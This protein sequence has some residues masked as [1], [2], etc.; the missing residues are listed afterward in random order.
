M[1]TAARALNRAKA[2]TPLP[3]VAELLPLHE[4][5]VLPRLGQ[6]MMI[7]GQPGAGKSTFVLWYAFKLGLDCLYFS[8]DMAAHTATTR[9]GALALDRTV[10]FVSDAVENGGTEFVQEALAES[11]IQW[12]F[13]SSPSL[14]DIADELA[15]YVEIW[16]KYPELII[17]DN[18][19]NVDGVG[20]DDVGG[21]RFVLSEL[22]R[23]CRETGS[24]VIALHHAREEGDPLRPS[25]RDKIQGKVSQLP[26]LIITVA[27]DGPEFLMAPVKNRNGFQDPTGNTYRRLTAHPE[28]ASFTTFVPKVYGY[29]YQ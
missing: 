20:G 15:A 3:I 22:H 24:A 19:L 1:L 25:P 4:L 8:A 14:D 10:S 17:V 2:A 26:E 16:D 5:G 13:D 18:V 6:L 28:K 21:I 27:L 12:C 23:L 7:V 9:H 29:G 11:R